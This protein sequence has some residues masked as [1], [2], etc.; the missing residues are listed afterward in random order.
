[1]F[2]ALRKPT[3]RI[4]QC[5]RRSVYGKVPQEK[6]GPVKSAFALFVFSV[7]LLGPAGWIL[8]HIPEYRQ[9]SSSSDNN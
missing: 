6:I 4:L 8:H 5:N 3:V 9:R 2:S 1:M 7:T